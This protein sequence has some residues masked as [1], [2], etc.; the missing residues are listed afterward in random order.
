MDRWPPHPHPGPL[1]VHSL[2]NQWLHGVTTGFSN[3][4]SKQMGQPSS[5]GATRLLS[6]AHMDMPA[7][8]AAAWQGRG[9]SSQGP[10][11]QL[12]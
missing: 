2:Q 6:G 7:P 4:I 5:S 3:G 12:Q 11:G 9:N 8:A 10:Q 1:N